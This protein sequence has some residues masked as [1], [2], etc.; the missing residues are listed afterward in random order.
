[1]ESRLLIPIYII[2]FFQASGAR[3]KSSNLD[4]L[5]DSFE[6]VICTW[7]PVKNAMKGQCQLT[8]SVKY[9]KPPKTCQMNGTSIRSYKLILEDYGLTIV[10]TILFVVSCYTGEKWIEVHN[11]TIKPFQNIQLQPP[12]N[13]QLENAHK[14]SYNLTWTLCVV[15][16]Y[17]SEKLE[18][19]IRYRATSSGENDTILPI[20]QDQK[21]LV[22][23]NL[24]PDTMFEAAIRVKVKQSEYYNSVWSRWSTPPL[25]WRTDL[26]ASP[27]S[28]HLRIIVA[29]VGSFISIF[30]IFLVFLFPASKCLRKKFK[31][32]LPDPAEFFP[33]LT[34]IH[35]G[36]IQQKWLS[37]PASIT[38]FHITAEAPNV[39]MLE[40]I[41]S[42]S[43]KSYLLPPKECFTNIENITETSGQSSGSCFTNRGY[44]FF[45]HLD[46]LE[47]DSCKVYFT[48]DAQTRNDSNSYFH[49]ELHEASHNVSSSIN[50]MS[51]QENDA[52]L[53]DYSRGSLPSGSD[54]PIA[55]PVEQNENT[56][57]RIPLVLSSKSPEQYSIDDSSEPKSSS[58]NT[59]GR[60]LLRNEDLSNNVM[61]NNRFMFSNQGQSNNICRT[62]SSSQIPSS[63]EAYLSLRDLQRHYSHHSV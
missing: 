58:R 14:P 16:H 53:Q 2:S 29:V 6:T 25:R 44:F 23:E 34:G 10:D 50:I 15:S 19:E 56:E 17:L 55:S 45:Q 27:Q 12:C 51:N 8:A 57:E 40:I 22:M 61:G 46:S 59:D 3:Q 28:A 30:I 41:Q 24:S 20:I 36:D 1:M 52:F 11:L 38:S 9:E 47:V 4:C 33:S 7:I 62:A 48:Y 37:S 18:Y 63:S 5:Y 42:C 35:G 13:F 39:S 31:I 32:N 49:K 26:E 21:W 43:K 54:F 60:E